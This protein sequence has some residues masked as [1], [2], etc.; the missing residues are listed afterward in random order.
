MKLIAQATH[1]EKHKSQCSLQVASWRNLLHENFLEQLDEKKVDVIVVSSQ[2]VVLALEIF[3]STLNEKVS[4]K[5]KEIFLQWLCVGLETEKLLETFLKN[6]PFANCNLL[7][8]ADLK[9]ESMGLESTLKTL[10]Q[11]QPQINVMVLGAAE[12]KLSRIKNQN[13]KFFEKEFRNVYE[14]AAYEIESLSADQQNTK[15]VQFSNDWLRNSKFQEVLL[16]A[17]SERIFIEAQRFSQFANAAQKEQRFDAVLHKPDEPV[18][19]L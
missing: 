3:L 11:F 14:L 19:K 13:A 4:S 1:L 9:I 7:K 5:M 18:Q 12:G 16:Q 15:L 6:S 17:R 8:R 2:T 10:S